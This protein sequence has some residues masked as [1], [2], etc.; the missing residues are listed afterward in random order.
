MSFIKYFILL[1]LF[2]FLP[3]PQFSSP[4]GCMGF[5]SFFSPHFAAETFSLVGVGLLKLFLF[6]PVLIRPISFIVSRELS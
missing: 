5:P 4:S 3:F 6:I 2:S 1:P